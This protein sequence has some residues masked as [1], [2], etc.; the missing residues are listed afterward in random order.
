MLRVIELS[1]CL[2]CNHCVTVSTRTA[3]AH[4]FITPVQVALMGPSGCGK[5]T[6]LDMMAGVKTA[7]YEGSTYLNGNEISR[8]PCILSC[9]HAERPSL[10]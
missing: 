7:E 6:L 1:D 8:Q 3:L 10:V 2:E 4:R 9:F 5:S